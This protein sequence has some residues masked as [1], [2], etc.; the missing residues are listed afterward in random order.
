[1]NF[2]NER[3]L[4][5]AARLLEQP[6]DYLRRFTRMELKI[7]MEDRKAELEGERL[8]WHRKFA[9]LFCVIINSN[10]WK[11]KGSPPAKVENFMPRSFSHTD[12]KIR[13]DTSF[14]DWVRAK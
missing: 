7:L 11:K 4:L 10:G 6:L 9:E 13:V 3:F 5:Q 14:T 1:M 12:G 2:Q 8:F